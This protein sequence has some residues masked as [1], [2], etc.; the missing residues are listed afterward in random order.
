MVYAMAGAL[1]YPLRHVR[2]RNLIIISAAILLFST[3]LF[4]VSGT[5]MGDARD[6]ASIVE[7]NPNGNHSNYYWTRRRYGMN[8][9]TPLSTMK[10]RSMKN[11]RFG[12]DPMARWRVTPLKTSMKNCS[13]SLSV[14][15]LGCNGNDDFGYGHVPAWNPFCCPFILV[16]CTDDG[17][18]FH[19]R[20]GSQRV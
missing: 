2:P 5:V 12:V 3:V 13:S 20:I 1:L 19:N 8:Q 15:A 9:K 7:E 14:H 10:Q 17:W 11:L 16:L 6:A 4:T 18:W